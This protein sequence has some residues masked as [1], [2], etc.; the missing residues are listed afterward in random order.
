M[1]K[2]VVIGPFVKATASGQ[3]DN[4]VEVAPLSDGG[5][6][7]R[8]SKRKTGPLL[9]VTNTGW[10]TFTDSLDGGDLG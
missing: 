8:D 3:Q 6:A 10:N 5:R 2:P 9:L 7:I 4:C 1:S